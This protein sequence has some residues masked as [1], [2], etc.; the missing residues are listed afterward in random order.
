MCV[1]RACDTA[2][3]A[4][5]WPCVAR[6]VVGSL[7]GS[8]SSRAC[9]WLLSCIPSSVPSARSTRT[10]SRRNGREARNKYGLDGPFGWQTSR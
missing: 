8:S 3:A 5:I 6:R 10:C 9:A 1:A 4:D 7:S 2:I